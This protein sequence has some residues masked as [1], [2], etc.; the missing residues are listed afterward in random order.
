MAEYRQNA[1]WS[2]SDHPRDSDGKF[3][4]KTNVHAKQER[5]EHKATVDLKPQRKQHKLSKRE[6][7]IVRSA[8][9]QKFAEYRR[10]GIP[11]HDYVY[12]GNSFVMF[13]NLGRDNFRVAIV[14]DIESDRELINEYL[15]G[16]K[17][18]Q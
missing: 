10:N 17:K 18:W 9:A 13:R 3:T 6:Y 7:A 1:D 11:K 12:T 2:E 14:L 15:S 4:Y 16:D 8:R 5:K